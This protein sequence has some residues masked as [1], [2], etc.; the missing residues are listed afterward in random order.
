M[1]L[2]SRTQDLKK[3]NSL[4]CSAQFYHVIAA[5]KPSHNKQQRLSP[6]MECWASIPT[7]TFGMTKMAE[8]SALYS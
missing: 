2:R 7:L 3:K 4:L 5:K 1:V 6:G 8:F